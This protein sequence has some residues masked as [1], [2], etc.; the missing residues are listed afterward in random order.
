M[1]YILILVSLVFCQIRGFIGTIQRKSCPTNVYF[2]HDNIYNQYQLLFKLKLQENRKVGI[3]L[4]LKNDSDTPDDQ[5]YSISR[6]DIQAMT[7]KQKAAVCLYRFALASASVAYTVGELTNLLSGSGLS[8][9][10]IST[11]QQNSHV[12][13]GCGILGAALLVPSHVQ[14]RTEDVDEDSVVGD[15][16]VLILNRSLPMLGSLAIVVEVMNSILN[17]VPGSSNFLI[18][19]FDKTADLFICALCLREIGFFGVAYKAEA[20]LTI[21]LCANLAIHDLIGF[22]EFALRGGAS[23][24]LLVLSFGKFFEPLEGD[25]RPNGSAFFRD[26]M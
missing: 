2:S 19:G 10:T 16:L 15:S 5:N 25:L 9:Q 11:I 3:P 17:N 13:F 1:K 7:V 8:I 22:P 24:G 21:F 14:T 20:V 12:I 4:Q 6:D 18:T 23:I 26:D